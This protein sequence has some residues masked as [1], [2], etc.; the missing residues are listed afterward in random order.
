MKSCVIVP[1]RGRPENMAR[2]AASFVGTDAH[3]DLYAVIDKDDPLLDQYLANK[4]Y[5]SLVIDNTT[6]GCAKALNSGA[7]IVLDCSVYPFYDI[8]IFMGDDSLPQ[9]LNWDQAYEKA[10]LGKSGFAY[11]DDLIQGENLPTQFAVTRDIV[12]RMQ[13]IAPPGITHLYV[14]NFAKQFGTDLGCLI[15]LPEVVIEH[16]HPMANTAEW[17]EGYYRVNNET[18]YKEDLLAMQI[19]LRSSEYADIVN[20]L[21]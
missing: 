8:F 20:A 9:T 16:L 14:D 13:G 2:L 12:E 5:T 7:Q 18:L 15:Y 19:Y 6:G 11:G 1:T 17:D 10:L 21:K 3:A 4:D